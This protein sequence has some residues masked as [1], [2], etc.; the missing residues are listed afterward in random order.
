MAYTHRNITIAATKILGI[1]RKLKFTFS[2]NAL[3]QIYLYHLLPMLEY[4]SLEGWM[5]STRF[6]YPTEH[7]K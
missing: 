5:D 1:M 2:R 7:T 6:Q 3:N 4:T